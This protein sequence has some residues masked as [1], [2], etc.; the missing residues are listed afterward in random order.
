ML[1]PEHFFLG[2]AAGGEYPDAI[3]SPLHPTVLLFATVQFV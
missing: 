1:G 2:L 3:V